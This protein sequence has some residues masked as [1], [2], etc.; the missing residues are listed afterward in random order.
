MKVK[1]LFILCMLFLLTLVSS[2]YVNPQYV[3]DSNPIVRYYGIVKAKGVDADADGVDDVLKGCIYYLDYE[4]ST[5]HKTDERGE[6]KINVAGVCGE[7]KIVFKKDGFKTLYKTFDL[8]DKINKFE[9][10]TLE[11]E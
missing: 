10:I 9:V 8:S 5:E 1:Y 11:K 4:G 3:Y 2:C 6:F 7:M